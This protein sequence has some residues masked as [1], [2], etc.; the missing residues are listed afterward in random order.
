LSAVNA[1]NGA[2][3]RLLGIDKWFGATHAVS[4]VSLDV[5]VGQIHA[6][7]GENG[8]GKS[9]LLKIA[10]GILPP[11]AGEVW[12]AGVRPPRYDA[13]RAQ[14]LGVAMVQQH[15]AL[16]G[17]MTALENMMVGAEP[18]RMAGRVDFAVARR[19]AAEVL[20]ELGVSLDLDAPVASL[21]VADRQRI[22][23]A[24]A[25]FRDSRAIILDEPTA[26]LTPQEASSLYA[27]LRRLA[28]G[29][30]AIVVVTHKLDEIDVHADL[31]TVM[32]RG[33]SLG[34]RTVRPGE[35]V[36]RLAG[37]LLGGLSSSH[38][39]VR[40]PAPPGDV[41]LRVKGLS[42][43]RLCDVSFDVAAGEI[44]G[45]AGVLGNGQ[46]ELVGI[47]GGTLRS[48]HGTVEGGRI[49]VVHEDRHEDGL[50]LGAT[51][52]DNL[53]LC[54][55]H[56]LSRW[57]VVDVVAQDRVARERI[58]RFG[59]I[60]RDTMVPVSSLSGGNQQ[61]VVLARALSQDPSVLVMA[62]PTRGVDVGAARAIHEHILTAARAGTAIVIVSADLAELRQL[63]T[64]I[65]VMARGRVVA[66]LPPDADDETIGTAMLGGTAAA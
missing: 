2:F 43:G 34:T 18:T 16:F 30:R 51:V 24:R 5:D 45:I 60:P 26:V 56:R 41:R 8:A 44:V 22:E 11:D 13:R 9:T 32:R 50:I 59:V 52:R 25:L 31:V 4:A 58:A 57:G 54:D 53:T 48:E 10:A 65:L 46:S 49:E 7:A 1:R 6:V 29:G 19:R 38:E 17:D 61:K 66:T 47:L 55:L 35:E 27:T 39:V 42:R 23:I 12:V 37:E 64:R 3:L 40:D 63:S 20:S 33:Q 28:K 15:F 14:D 36:S 21:G 62:H